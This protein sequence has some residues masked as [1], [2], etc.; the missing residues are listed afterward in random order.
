MLIPEVQNPS[1]SVFFTFCLHITENVDDKFYV[2][3][4]EVSL[5]LS[6]IIIGHPQQFRQGND[7]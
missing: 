7:K 1:V 6:Y 5:L 2:A 3:T 4:M